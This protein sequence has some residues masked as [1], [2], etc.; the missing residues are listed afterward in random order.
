MS[1]P[2]AALALL[3]AAATQHPGVGVLRVASAV[4]DGETVTI[5]ST[6]FEADFTSPASVTA[7]RRAIDL[8]AAASVVAAARVLTLSG[9][10]VAAETVSMGGVTYTWRASVATTANEV[11]VGA[12]AA[13]SIQNLLAAVNLTAGAGTT[14]GSATVINP[15]VS[16]T[17][18]ATTVTAT[19]KAKG[20]VGNS[21]V[22]GEAM[23]NASWASAATTLAGGTDASAADFTT[24]LKAAIDASGDL[25]VQAVRVSANEVLVYSTRPAMAAAATTETLAGSN[26]AWGAATLQGGAGGGE[27]TLPIAITVK[28][29]ATTQEVALGNMHFVFAF[30]PTIALVEVQTTAGVPKAFDGVA[31]ITGNRVTVD[32]S[33]SSDWSAGDLVFVQA[34]K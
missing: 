17:G 9:N 25:G 19:A 14:Y 21:I 5:G 32:N 8:S 30:S 20:T 27:D 16:A 11:L 18:D 13:A 10:A 26:N 24:A 29:A 15:Q 3:S 2:L 4:Q 34:S 12:N 31:T 22:V 33:G 1:K 28:R 6:V 23:T 7:G